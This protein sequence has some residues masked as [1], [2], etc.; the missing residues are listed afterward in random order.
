MNTV[1]PKIQNQ[2]NMLSQMQQQLQTVASQKGQY[3]LAVKEARRALEELDD[4][5]EDAVIYMTIGNVV[6]QKP[7]DAVITGLN[8]KI[9]G[10]ELRTSSIEKQEKLIQEKFDKLQAQVKEAMEKRTPHEDEE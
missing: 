2:I 9:D 5:K 8:E 6:M 4:A 7:K 3:E 1:S 10:F